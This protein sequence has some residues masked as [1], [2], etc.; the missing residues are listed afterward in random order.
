MNEE[1]IAAHGLKKFD[2][3]E[4]LNSPEECAAYLQEFIDEEDK[5]LLFQAIGDVLKAQRRMSQ[6]SRE[7]GISREG[8]YKALGENGNPS[9]KSIA[10]LLKM[11]GLKIS[12]SPAEKEEAPAF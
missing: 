12:I 7:I 11:L 2:A 6:A 1:F 5:T 3:S 8:L 9:F 4:Y 10:D